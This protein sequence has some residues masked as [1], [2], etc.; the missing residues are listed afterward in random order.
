MLATSMPDV[1]S[2]FCEGFDS[3]T[4]TK[5]YQNDN[6]VGEKQNGYVRKLQ[7]SGKSKGKKNL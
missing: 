7:I 6:N 3:T 5:M 4:A 1:M 2:R